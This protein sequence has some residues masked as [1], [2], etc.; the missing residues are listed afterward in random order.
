MNLQKKVGH[1]LL[2]YYKRRKQSSSDLSLENCLQVV[3]QTVKNT[4][5]CFL[6]TSGEHSWASARL[7]E[8]ICDLEEL[9]FFI[10]TNPALRKVREIAACPK[11]TLAFG[12]TAENANLVVYGTAAVSTEPDIKRRYW[13]GTWRL[14]FPKGA[15]GDDY[16]VIKVRAQWLELLSFQRNVIEEPFGLRPMVLHRTVDGSQIQAQQRTAPADGFALGRS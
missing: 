5:Y 3:R 13:K 4:K 14:F 8:P 15:N 1:F 16:A 7:V 11:V 10:G 2:G 6:I 9:A 12:N